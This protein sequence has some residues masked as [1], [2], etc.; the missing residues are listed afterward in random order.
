MGQIFSSSGSGVMGISEYRLRLPEDWCEKPCTL[1]KFVRGVFGSFTGRSFDSH[2]R[3]TRSA[4]DE[5]IISCHN[6]LQECLKSGQFEVED[7]RFQSNAPERFNVGECRKAF[8]ECQ[9]RKI[10]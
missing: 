7:Q 8:E 6:Q 3:L 9:D 10:Y 4:N 5:W 1:Q 2:N